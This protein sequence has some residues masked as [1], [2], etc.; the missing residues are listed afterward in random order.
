MNSERWQQVKQLLDEVI[1]VDP[2]QRAAHLDH[3]CGRD[4]ELRNEVESL[5]ASHE[6][7]GTAFLKNPALELKPPSLSSP[8]RS[9][10]R[11]G[12][13]QI[14][15]EIGHGG[16]GEVYRAVRADGQYTK[17]VAIKLV[18]GGLDSGLVRDRFRNERQILA[19][20]DHPNIARLLDGGTTDDGV[21]YLVMELIDGERIDLYCDVRK[22]STTERL[23]LFRQVCGAV[24]FAH[25]RLVI[26]RDIKPSNILVTK[27]GV[28]KLLDFGI[29]KLLDPGSDA[30]STLGQA[31]TPDYA[32]PEQIRGESITTSTDVYS[33]GV[34]LYVL[35]T[36]RSPYP[37]ETRSPLQLARA[38]CET[39]P[40]RPST[41]V[42]KPPA[43]SGGNENEAEQPTPE[44]MSSSREG[45]PAKLRRRLVGDLDNIVLKA[46]RKEQQRRYASAEQ[47]AEDIRRHLD[48]RPVTA[49]PDSFLYRTRKF[50]RRNKIVVTAAT[51]IALA[52]LGGVLATIREA[53][54]A[55]MQR[56]RA[57]K[58]FNDVRQL[59]D[60][61]IFDVHDAIQNLPGAT[62]A[63]KLLLD[64][65]LDYL[66]GVSKDAAG[67]PDLEREL[68]WGYQRIAVVQGSSSESNLGD[69]E[70]GLASD[71]KAL[72]L[73][74]AVAK[75]NPDNTIDQLNV[76]MMHRILAFSSL[77]QASGHRDLEQAM[78]ITERL[79]QRDPAN[80]KVRS[81]RS[82]EY[83]NLALMRDA[84]GERVLALEAYRKNLELKMGLLKTNP[85]YR[86]VRR[87]IGMASVM[88]GTALARVGSREEGLKHVEEGIRF[89]E[90]QPQG[91]DAINIK[92]ELNIARQKR[93][94]IWLMNG[95]RS[96]ALQ[97]YRDSRSSLKPMAKADPQNTLLQLDV[98]GMDYHQGRALALAGR[99][100]EALAKMQLSLGV[101]EK[102]R[103]LGRSS[104][105]SPH[106]TGAIYIW[107]GEFFA[108]R[109]DL[110]HSLQHYEKAI[111][112]LG[113]NVTPAMDDDAR[114]ELATSYM[115]MG[116]A[117]TR[118]GSL[119]DAAS[120]YQKALEIANPPVA[121]EHQD[122]P[123]LY[124]VAEAQAGLG[125]V[126]AALA[127]DAHTPEERSRSANEAR[128]SYR[129]SLETWRQVPNPTRISPSG[130]LSDGP[131]E[132]P[133][134]GPRERPRN[135]SRHVT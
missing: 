83:Q 57:E 1:L 16:M 36:G 29:A 46:L 105:D 58:R 121:V 100:A 19:S 89:F 125:D 65:A 21:P 128:T 8:S 118:M 53:R 90:S 2:M 127:R 23:Q 31:M 22:L 34:V 48:G 95:D 110:H 30:Q 14:I 108:L 92:R 74:E 17:E 132:G 131:R 20:L 99:H 93:G 91:D 11:I 104:D 62:P 44:Q 50:V 13:Y 82:I 32:S 96:G 35:L 88:L 9:G 55:G 54:I 119:H 113:T 102:Y 117:L 4:S 86:R 25:Q 112:S 101:F 123:A 114:C 122:V 27:D 47:F 42:L 72:A 33:L 66:D 115:K 43:I 61:L 133:R 134:A 26:H 68:A 75:T 116:N 28:P 135:L 38:V 71:R 5:L 124:I 73:F 98:A 129:Q 3:S 85:D 12:V 78:A 106:G 67:D 39:D 81:E 84:A 111:A 45:S 69:V 94:D 80:P 70:A 24:H 120:A 76:A 51:V 103:A 130:F 37:G 97:A 60:S 40:S 77:M 18:R 87:G 109:G 64:R 41:A 56:A 63:R 52:I 7:A 6:Q 79:L 59:S 49:T 107:L 15:D 126:A 10:R